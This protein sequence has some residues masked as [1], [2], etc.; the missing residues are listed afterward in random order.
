MESRL[1]L[2]FWGRQRGCLLPISKIKLPKESRLLEDMKA[3]TTSTSSD[4]ASKSTMYPLHYPAYSPSQGY[5]PSV[6]VSVPDDS[7]NVPRTARKRNHRPK[8]AIPQ[9]QQPQPYG[10]HNP[11]F[12]GPNL[13]GPKPGQWSDVYLDANG[14]YM[15]IKRRSNGTYIFTF[16]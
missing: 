2:L 6:E 13:K 12:Q 3:K 10:N 8:K 4:K 15:Q 7:Y 14:T 5:R 16:I 1:P 11:E 9:Y